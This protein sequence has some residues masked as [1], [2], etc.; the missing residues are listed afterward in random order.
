MSSREHELKMIEQFVAR[1]KE[2]TTLSARVEER[3][4]SIERSRDIRPDRRKEAQTEP[5]VSPAA[6][7]TPPAARAR[8]FSVRAWATRDWYELLLPP[9]GVVAVPSGCLVTGGDRAWRRTE[10]P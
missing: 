1:M 10:V 6:V 8:F 3:H 2:A 4:R 5:T 9:R 7:P